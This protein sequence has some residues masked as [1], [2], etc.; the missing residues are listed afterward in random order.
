[1]DSKAVL[2]AGRAFMFW[3]ALQGDLQHKAP[4][5]ATREKASDYM[6]LMTPVVKA[7]LTDRGYKACFD[8]MQVHGGSGFTEHF[9]ASQYLRDCRISA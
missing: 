1:M 2:E 3:T 5:E 7:Y 4:D 6:G 9:P 8:G